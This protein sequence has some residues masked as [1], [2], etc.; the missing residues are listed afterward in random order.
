M[1]LWMVI[2]GDAYN[3]GEY[4][5]LLEGRVGERMM[6]RVRQCSGVKGYCGGYYGGA[7]H[8]TSAVGV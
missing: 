1:V 4:G 2:G 8:F 3:S 6:Q 7:S 5:P